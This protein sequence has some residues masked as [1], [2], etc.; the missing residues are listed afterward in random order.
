MQIHPQCVTF[1]CR[2]CG[3]SCVSTETFWVIAFMENSWGSSLTR[4]TELSMLKVKMINYLSKHI[5]IDRCVSTLFL[6]WRSEYIQENQKKI[7]FPFSCLREFS[8]NFPCIYYVARDITSSSLVTHHQ[9]S[10]R[11][12]YSRNYS[13]WLISRMNVCILLFF[14]GFNGVLS[15]KINCNLFT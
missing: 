15:S 7:N 5:E 8:F 2:E 6:A 13:L 1:F 14:L 12:L 3:W 10:C 9:M 11:L 4:Q